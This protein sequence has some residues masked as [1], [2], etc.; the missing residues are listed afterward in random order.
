MCI[1][2]VRVYFVA[3]RRY[4]NRLSQGFW[5]LHIHNMQAHFRLISLSLSLSLSFLGER[6]RDKKTQNR[7][8]KNKI[9][10]TKQFHA[11]YNRPSSF[12]VC[13]PG[14]TAFKIEK[15]ERSRRRRRKKTWHHRC[16]LENRWCIVVI[17]HVIRPPRR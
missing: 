10:Y 12:S 5:L 7:K 4:Y 8:I 16:E 15:R 6:K 9:M 1:Y 17:F 14:P 3:I 13:C 2:F 11:F